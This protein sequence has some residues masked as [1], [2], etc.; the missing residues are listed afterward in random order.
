MTTLTTNQL[1]ALTVFHGA[2][3]AESDFEWGDYFWME[4][5]LEMLTDNGWGRK[6]AE[7]TIGSL[8][9]SGQSGVDAH[10]NTENPCK[11]D[12]LEMLYV[13]HHDHNWGE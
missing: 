4:D 10:S 9:D 5:L 12:K 11:N 7:G 13:V 6:A 3:E 1:N 8:L 2:I